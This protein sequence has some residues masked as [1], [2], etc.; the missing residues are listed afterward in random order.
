MTEGTNCTCVVDTSGLFAISVAS[1]NL[2]SILLD[3]L[4]SGM[5][6]VP[7]CAWQEFSEL[8]EDKSAILA[9]YIGNKIAMKKSIYVGAASIAE[10]LNSGFSRGAYDNHIELYTASIAAINGY[11]VLTSLDQFSQYVKMG[12]NVIDIETWVEGI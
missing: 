10:K 11:R 8:Y 9:P 5:I 3:E 1:G 12:C 2:Q 4:K 6:G 7:A